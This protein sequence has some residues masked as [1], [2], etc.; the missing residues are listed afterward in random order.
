MTPR[1]H[2]ARVWGLSVLLACAAAALLAQ[3][4]P[5]DYLNWSASQAESIGKEMYVKGR[6]GGI[7]DTRLLKTERSYN[8]KLAATWLT[9]QVIRA[10]ARLEQLRQRLSVDQTRALVAAAEAAGDTVI[11]VEIDPR[12]GSGV[13]PSDWVAFLQPAGTTDAA[14]TVSGVN[15]PRLR[16][17]AALAGVLRRNYDYD[18]FW[19][20]FPLK[21]SSG[22]PLFSASDREAELIVRIYDKEGRVHWPILDSIR[23]RLAAR[24]SAK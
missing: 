6:V 12:E 21:T 17:V 5:D 3:G 22:Q 2:R 9:P 19:V 8:Y 13:I 24:A 14:R 7:W 10:A 23:Q 1:R 4:A 18:R 15:S 11:M 20:I 16:D